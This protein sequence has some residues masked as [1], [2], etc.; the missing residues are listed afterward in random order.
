MLTGYLGSTLP[1]SEANML[2][3][4]C[5]PHSGPSKKPPVTGTPLLLRVLVREEEQRA[6][7]HDAEGTLGQRAL[8]GRDDGRRAGLVVEHQG[9]DLVAVDPTL[10]VLECHA[11][12]EPG[13]G[14]AELRRARAGQRR[15]HRDR[16]RRARRRRRWPRRRQRSANGG[17]PCDRQDGESQSAQV[18]PRRYVHVRHF[19]P[20]SIRPTPCQGPIHIHA[21]SG[22]AG[23]RTLRPAA[24]RPPSSPVR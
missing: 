2:V 22:A 23:F 19:P 7:R 13:G 15:D 16:D 17:S 11:G 20:Q 8:D 9:V 21:R 10:R 4:G 6:G 12:V 24:M 18:H 1:T 3:K 14:L 5:V